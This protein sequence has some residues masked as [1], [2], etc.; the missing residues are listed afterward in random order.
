[1]KKFNFNYVTVLL[2]VLM[3]V[4][5]TS[6]KDDNG[7]E[8]IDY[9]PVL[10]KNFSFTVNANDVVFT[11]TIPGNVWFTVEG[12]DYPTVDKT[13][14]VNLPLKGTYSVTC[15]TLGS[16]VTLTSAAF[17][18]VIAADDL[19]FLEEGIWKALTGGADGNKVWRLDDFMSVGG[20]EY[21]KFFTSALKYYQFTGDGDASSWHNGGHNLYKGD[22]TG[23]AAH[24]V[25]DS[26][27]EIG[28]IT[29]NGVTRKA[30]LVME[31]GVDLSNGETS[32]SYEVE[33][34]MSLTIQSEAY[35]Y[36]TDL[37]SEY[38]MTFSDEWAKLSFVAPVRMP[39]DKGRVKLGEFT[40]ETL[41]N[42]AII[43]CTDSAL[44][45]S[46]ERVYEADG[47][48]NHC[49]LLYNFICDNYEYTYDDPDL[50]EVFTYTEPVKTSFTANDLVG[51]WKYADMPQG[52]IAWDAA[53]DQGT[54]I[55]AHMFGKWDT[56]EQV[57]ADLTSWGFTDPDAVFTA[58]EGNTYVFNNDGT[59]TLNGV[60]NTYTV[61]N[62]VI[63]FGTALAG[64]EW[65]LCW[66][67]LSG[68]ELKAIDVQYY[69]DAVEAY[70]PLGIWIGQQNE[71]K[72]EYKAVQLVKQ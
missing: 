61:A 9:T 64:T 24:N 16:G 47:S 26:G 37:E 69:G 6:C 68:T 65:S 15:S 28:T 3:M 33:G 11:T 2:G 51:T 59:C 18:V 48:E 22:W 43:S 7:E 36:K 67:A 56:R 45:V 32:A 49:R 42:V 13:V 10:N 70:T 38:G 19:S 5:I 58:A 23:F 66:L 25:N 27:P 71:A 40:D 39:L 52:W 63:T 20:N 35:G 30:K 41:Y 44:I 8:T 53:G 54:N 34:S 72:N 60:A 62:G 57:V 50:A 31:S 14:T 4:F 29:F 46:V 17:D 55:P 21:N 1:M 12:T